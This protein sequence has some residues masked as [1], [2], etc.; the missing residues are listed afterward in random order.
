MPDPRDTDAE[1]FPSLKKA[2]HEREQR[3]ESKTRHGADEGSFNKALQGCQCWRYTAL[4]YLTSFFLT[5]CN[6]FGW[7]Q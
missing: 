1:L 6:D 5:N 3:L 2:N 4:D 7:K